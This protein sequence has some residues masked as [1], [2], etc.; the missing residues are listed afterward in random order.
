MKT[1]IFV[2]HP[3]EFVWVIR[4]LT[5]C[6]P[7]NVSFES[8]QEW[9]RLM[10]LFTRFFIAIS[11]KTSASISDVGFI[12][13]I[14]KWIALWRRFL[15]SGI[16]GWEEHSRSDIWSWTVL[17]IPWCRPTIE[18]TSDP[19]VRGWDYLESNG[20]TNTYIWLIKYDYLIIL[21][22]SKKIFWLVTAYWVDGAGTKRSLQKK[23]Q[24][25]VI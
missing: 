5:G 11:S 6:K 19:E 14:E 25:R 21:Q 16:Q 10:P 13:M 18:H 12:L 7:V 20:R 15:A 9:H 23:Y 2:W 3:R 4:Y 22:R 1:N 8:D 17:K 24:K